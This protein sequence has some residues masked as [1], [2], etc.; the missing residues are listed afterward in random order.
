MKMIF[1]VDNCVQATTIIEMHFEIIDPGRSGQLKR[2]SEILLQSKEQIP[3]P[4]NSFFHLLRNRHIDL[5][6]FGQMS[7][8]FLMADCL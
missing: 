8:R 1:G 4:F 6:I 5:V 3:S 2:R 7:V